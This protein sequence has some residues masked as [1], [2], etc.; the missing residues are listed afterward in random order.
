MT[1]KNLVSQLQNRLH[2]M[3]NHLLAVSLFIEN[4]DSP[5]A[6]SQEE[7][8]IIKDRVGLITNDLVVSRE[9]TY[10]LMTLG[11]EKSPPELFEGQDLSVIS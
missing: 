2:S 9:L 10:K 5:E 8:E 1:P 11:K 6:I 4:T 7:F 3:S